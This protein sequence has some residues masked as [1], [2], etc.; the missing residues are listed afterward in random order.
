M[1]HFYLLLLLFT[2]TL[3]NVQ[4]QSVIKYRVV[5][6]SSR[7]TGA[8]DW[9]EHI[10]MNVLAV[11]NTSDPSF[12]FYAKRTM[13]YDVLDLGDVQIDKDGDK[14]ILMT[15][16]D[17]E[18]DKVMGKMI[19][20]SDGSGRVQFYLFYSAIGFCYEMEVVS[21]SDIGPE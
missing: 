8:S 5:A 11:L 10:K 13:R 20:Y 9:S 1:K 21:K 15:C 18:G 4:A 3:A 17:D 2:L 12:T 7:T 6:K 16:L 19:N 14:Y